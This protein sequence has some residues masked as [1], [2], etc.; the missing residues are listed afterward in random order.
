MSTF[1]LDRQ[2]VA[3]QL[4]GLADGATRTQGT[5]G[6]ESHVRELVLALGT[7]PRPDMPQS[8]SGGLSADNPAA[9]ARSTTPPPSA[10]ARQDITK[11]GAE[12]QLSSPGSPASMAHSP[13]V[14]DC[15]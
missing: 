13:V 11:G 10:E 2:E 14:S 1:F 15:V 7:A 4:T 5:Q 9:P 12:A 6:E 3:P 8:N